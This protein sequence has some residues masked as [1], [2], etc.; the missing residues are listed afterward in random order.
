MKAA[1]E[2]LGDIIGSEGTFVDPRKID[3]I[4]K[5]EVPATLTYFQFF[6][7]FSTTIEDSLRTFLR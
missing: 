5:W 7:G 3:P 1:L 4:T 6:R 2:Y